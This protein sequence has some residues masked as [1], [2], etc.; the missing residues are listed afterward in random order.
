MGCSIQC[1]GCRIQQDFT[2]FVFYVP[3]LE[4]GV[5]YLGYWPELRNNMAIDLFGC[6]VS[7]DVGL[8]KT[9]REAWHEARSSRILQFQN[10]TILFKICLIASL[11]IIGH[12]GRLSY[13]IIRLGMKCVG[14]EQDT[15]SRTVGQLGNW[16]CQHYAERVGRGTRRSLREMW[17]LVIGSNY[18]STRSWNID[19]QHQRHG[20]FWTSRLTSSIHQQLLKYSFL[21][22]SLFLTFTCSKLYSQARVNKD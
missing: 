15:L 11:L 10:S 22:Q 3:H 17:G 9:C 21:H 19:T 4:R 20:L 2:W 6:S 5:G 18:E 1:P 7:G 13:L 8:M 14:C 12:A 16:E